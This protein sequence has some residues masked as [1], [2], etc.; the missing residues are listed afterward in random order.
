MISNSMNPGILR[1]QISY[2]QFIKSNNG[3]NLQSIAILLTGIFATFSARKAFTN[4]SYVELIPPIIYVTTALLAWS[5]KNAA[6]NLVTTEE[7]L[8]QNIELGT[9]ASA[10]MKKI[11]A[12]LAHET[13][14]LHSAN[15]KIQQ[16][17]MENLYLIQEVARLKN[18]KNDAQ[19]SL[20][21]AEKS[22]AQ[23][24]GLEE[25]TSAKIKK[26]EQKLDREKL[27]LHSAN[28]KIQQLEMENL[29]L[30]NQVDLFRQDQ[31]KVEAFVK[32]ASLD[33]QKIQGRLQEKNPLYTTKNLFHSAASKIS[34]PK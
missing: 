20:L 18:S 22:L 28:E 26:I 25:T 24:M 15:E 32:K 14:A 17:E 34:I 29:S 10:R 30:Y 2:D 4:G 11:E 1:H 27:A 12:E 19:F 31:K 5:A 13:S 8:A 3:Q 16:I 6:I 9:K 7:S 33:V 21:K 23:K